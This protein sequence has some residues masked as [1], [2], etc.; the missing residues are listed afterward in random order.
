M[1]DLDRMLEAGGAHSK[2]FLAA[3]RRSILARGLLPRQGTIL[4]GVSGGKDSLSLAIVLAWLRRSAGFAFKVEA[5]L[6]DWEDSGLGGPDLQKLAGFLDSIGIAFRV[7][8]APFPAND[9]GLSP[10][11]ACSRERKRIL[12]SEALRLGAVHVAL[13]HHRDDAAATVLMNLVDRGRAEGLPARRDFFGGRIILIRPLIDMPE[14]SISA[15]ARRLGLP[16]ADRACPMRGKDRRS[17]L[18][19]ILRS[20]EDFKPGAKRFLTRAGEPRRKNAAELGLDG[21]LI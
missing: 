7:T 9:A 8:G 1:A 21:S 6:V 11:Y 4:V 19:P 5:L 3:A 10:C 20:L 12:F 18:K 2:R 13:G 16:V 17:R 15:F 14:A